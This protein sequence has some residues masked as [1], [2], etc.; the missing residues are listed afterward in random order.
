[1]NRL[2]LI[3][4]AADGGRSATLLGAAVL[5]AAIYTADALLVTLGDTGSA[6]LAANVA[7]PL[8]LMAVAPLAFWLLYARPRGKSPI[9]VLPV[10]YLGGLA[11]AAMSV[12]GAF[13]LVPFLLVVAAAVD[14][15]VLC[16]EVPRLARLTRTLND[17]ANSKQ[18]SPSERF[19]HCSEGVLGSSLPARML[20]AELTMWWYLLRS[21][22]RR[23]HSPEGSVPFSYHRE[24]NAAALTGVLVFLA[25]IEAVVAHV[26]LSKISV[27]I[28]V[29]ATLATAYMLAW[30]VAN[31]R[32]MALEPILVGETSVLARWDFMSE[33]RFE[34]SSVR[35]VVLGDIDV[36]RAERA[37]LSSL[38]GS[39]CWVALESPVA[40]RPLLGK[41][42]TVRYVK[43]SPDDPAGFKRALLG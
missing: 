27:A 18:L 10:I 20:A 37:D 40:Y 23:P 35:E 17:E 14:I 38:G 34:R 13:S 36:P 7:L 33:L 29:A 32:A 30:L 1:M 9:L 31:T 22:G 11:S 39:P 24:S 6:A 16:L 25:A 19:R 26:A 21:W 28:A 42:R 8:D 4:T 3:G 12:E 41:A 2:K 43:V 15:V 5:C